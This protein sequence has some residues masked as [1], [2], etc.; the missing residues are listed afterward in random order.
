MY[1]PFINQNVALIS[2]VSEAEIK[3]LAIQ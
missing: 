3:S 1:Q 2:I